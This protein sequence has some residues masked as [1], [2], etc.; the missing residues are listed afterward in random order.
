M[1]IFMFALLHV[2]LRK[3]REYSQSKDDKDDKDEQIIKALRNYEES[4]LS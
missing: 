4:L 1:A 2:S 3:M